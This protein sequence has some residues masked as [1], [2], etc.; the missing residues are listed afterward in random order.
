MK[1]SFAEI[2]SAQSESNRL[3]SL[4]NLNKELSSAKKLD[5]CS[6]CVPSIDEYYR[7]CSR[8]SQLNNKMQVRVLLHIPTYI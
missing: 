1:R 4:N 5:E 7:K 6:K 3:L 8:I 2:D